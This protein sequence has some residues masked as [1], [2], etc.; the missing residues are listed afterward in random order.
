MNDSDATSNIVEQTQIEETASKPP[1]PRWVFKLMNPIMKALL[2]SPLHR[3]VSGLIM[4]IT[5]TGRKTGRVYTIPIGYF[6]WDENELMSTSGARWWKNVRDGRAVTLLVRGQRVEAIPTV[7]EEREAVI[8]TVEDFIMRVGLADARRIPL[9]LPTD[10]EPT[11]E[12]L[13]AIPS[14]RVFIHFEIVGR[15]EAHHGA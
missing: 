1:A 13:R 9:G 8:Q 4:L 3:P 12:D 5:Y 14:D 7:I 10:C 11:R 2:R 6:N 15:P